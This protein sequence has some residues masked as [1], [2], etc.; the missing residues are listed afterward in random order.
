MWKTQPIRVLNL[1]L[2]QV[3]A[4][5]PPPPTKDTANQ[6]VLNLTMSRVFFSPT[7]DKYFPPT[8]N[9]ANL[10]VLILFVTESGVF[11]P[12][13]RNSQ[14]DDAK[15][16]TLSRVFFTQQRHRQM[17]GTEFVTGWTVFFHQLTPNIP[18]A[19]RSL[20]IMTFKGTVLDLSQ[21]THC[22]VNGL[23]PS[24]G[25]GGTFECTV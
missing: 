23:Q 20:T 3:S 21:S 4:P 9:T 15:F 10:R 2:S 1:T 16:D 5:P 13:Q 24:S 7:K 8:K 17:E 19:S 12:Y 25:N 6:R 11:F 18:D 14:P 22:N